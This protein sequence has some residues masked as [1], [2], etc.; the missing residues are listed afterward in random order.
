MTSDES[1][2]IIAILAAV[3]IAAI[4]GIDLIDDTTQ[5]APLDKQQIKAVF[6]CGRLQGRIDITTV[7]NKNL[8][9]YAE[10]LESMKNDFKACA[11]LGLNT[12]LG[13]EGD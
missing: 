4:F 12:N 7:L 8:G 13:L 5:T 2:L 3:V 9:G 11:D 6:E 10:T 1:L